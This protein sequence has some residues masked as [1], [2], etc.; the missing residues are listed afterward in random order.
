MKFE[1]LLVLMAACAAGLAIA[2]EKAMAGQGQVVFDVQCETNEVE[3][4][5][6]VRLTLKLVVKKD[7]EEEEIS[8]D[9]QE[10]FPKGTHEED[11]T[12]WFNGKLSDAKYSPMG[13]EHEDGSRTIFFTNI[14]EIDTSFNG[15]IKIHLS[16][17]E[18]AEIIEV[19]MRAGTGNGGSGK[20]S[21]RIACTAISPDGKYSG[22]MF[23]VD[24]GYGDTS[25]IIILKV[26]N[27]AASV[28]ILAEV[29]SPDKVVLTAF[30]DGRP[31]VG[32]S[33][34]ISMEPLEDE[35]YGVHTVLTMEE[36]E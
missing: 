33:I 7:D 6:T 16:A 30:A 11:I 29:V 32:I 27:S 4:D 21:Y 17:W 28:G 25:E 31:V 24:L 34:S 18:G 13:V 2:S 5:T 10:T 23:E 26:A 8:F 15:Q 36:K 12:G 9:E 22:R 14:N 1:C 35:W 19:G 20:G 3:Y